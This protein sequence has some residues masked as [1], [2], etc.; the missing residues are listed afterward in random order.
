[1]EDCVDSLDRIFEAEQAV[2]DD[3]NGT[4]TYILCPN[5]TYY[6]AIALNGS[7]SPVEGE[8][9]LTIS[10][11]NVLILCGEDGS[12]TNNCLLSGGREQLVFADVFETNQSVT[13]ALVRGLTFTDALTRNVAVRNNGQLV[14]D[15]CVFKVRLEYSIHDKWQPCVRLTSCWSRVTHHGGT[16]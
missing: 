3:T 10:R 12:S 6:V 2:E 7:G 13:N 16:D 15:D 4:R 14:L 1:M 9:P 5:T 11:S 8:H